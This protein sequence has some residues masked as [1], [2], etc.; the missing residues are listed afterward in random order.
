MSLKTG[1]VM[2]E[3][4]DLDT[5]LNRTKDFAGS[6]VRMSTTTPSGGRS[7]DNSFGFIVGLDIIGLRMFFASSL[8]LCLQ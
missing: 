1:L 5:H 2:V 8:C 4:Q 3:F 7:D 6:R